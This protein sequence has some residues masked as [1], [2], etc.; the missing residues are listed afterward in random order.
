MTRTFALPLTVTV[1]LCGAMVTAQEPPAGQGGRG[2]RQ[3]AAG[4]GPNFPQQQRQLADAAVLAR[5]KGL[6][7]ANCSACHGIDLRGGQQGGP[8][9]LRSQ[10]VLLDKAGEGIGAVLKDGRPT[11]TQAGATPMPPFPFPPEDVAAIAEY[12]H[13]VAAQAGRQGRPPVD[14]NVPAEKILVGDPAAGKAYFDAKCSAC[15]SLDGDLK[16]LASRVA[17][18]RELQNAWVSGGGGGRGGR[19][20]RGGG[21]GRAA[22]VTITPASGAPAN[23]RLLRIDDFTVSLLLEDGTRRTFVRN[24]GDPKI[25]IQDPAEAHRRLVMAL[26]DKDMH[27]VTAYLWSLR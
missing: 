8:N 9:L 6:F 14:E 7:E 21:G 22:T 10:I 13:S 4:R 20:G 3:G 11:P 27:D 17:D 15:H 1:L 18:A 26:A 24:G 2:G 19:G 5:G 16:G 25:D 23:G 12:I